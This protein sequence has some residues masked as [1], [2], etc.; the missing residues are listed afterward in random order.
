M[1][2]RRAAAAALAVVGV[3]TRLNLAPRTATASGGGV[4]IIL[5]EVRDAASVADTSALLVLILWLQCSD[6][7][8]TDTGLLRKEGC[9][10]GKFRLR[11]FCPVLA[12]RTAAGWR[13]RHQGLG[14]ICVCLS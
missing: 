5:Q 14:D 10:C 9:V 11:N 6:H 4:I 2:R 3:D 7:A 12:V 1:K 8:K 13:G